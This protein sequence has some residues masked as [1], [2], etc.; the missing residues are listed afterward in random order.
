M[1]KKI[2]IICASDV[3]LAPFLTHLQVT[4]VTLKAMLK[5]YEGIIMEMPIVIVYSGVCK[6]NAAIA[7]QLMIDLFSPE[8]IVNAGTAGG[9]D[10]T[11]ELFDTII[12]T[13]V[14]Y[15]DVADDILTEFHPWLKTIYFQLDPDLL[16]AAKQYCQ[17]AEYP[18]HLGTTVSG[19]QFIEENNRA[20]IKQQYSPLSVDMETASIAHVCHVNEIPFIAIRTITDTSSHQGIE[21]FEQNCQK[22]SFIS[23]QIVIDFLKTLL[24]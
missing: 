21:Q 2:G 10:E 9:I 23:S 12:S 14:C 13:K 3:E 18:I 17:T 16:A 7:C 15:H 20:M 11:V 4:S 19:E 22:A 5:F 24:T 1:I 8:I 6:V